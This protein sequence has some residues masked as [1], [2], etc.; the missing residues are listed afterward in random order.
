MA[1]DFPNPDSQPSNEQEQATVPT[2][3][4]VAPIIPLAPQ[5][6]KRHPLRIA[7]ITVVI[8]LLVAAV[9]FGVLRYFAPVLVVQSYMHDGLNGKVDVNLLCPAQQAEAEASAKLLASQPSPTITIDTSHLSFSV[10]N[11]SLN[12]ATVAIGGSID[13]GS[14]A[15]S[16]PVNYQVALQANGLW[17]CV[18]NIRGGPNSTS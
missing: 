14:S 9:G 3:P 6:K 8:V 12:S 1:S 13:A 7:I 15:T 17:W 16:V 18:N 4:A 5:R 2:D 11:E 10:Q